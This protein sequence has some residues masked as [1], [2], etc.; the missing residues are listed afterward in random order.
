MCKIYGKNAD[1]DI[2]IIIKKSIC[3]NICENKNIRP[4]N[5]VIKIYSFSPILICLSQI[6][7]KKLKK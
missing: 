1:Y 5:Y 7:I 6:Q 2:K 4:Y 3:V